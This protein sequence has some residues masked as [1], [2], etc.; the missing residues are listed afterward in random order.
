M[1]EQPAA[2][3]ASTEE[4][5]AATGKGA[6][7]N[8]R[9][10]MN[11]K[12]VKALDDVK[13]GLATELG[14]A[15]TNDKGRLKGTEKLTSLRKALFGESIEAFDEDFEE[16]YP[17]MPFDSDTKVSDK[18]RIIHLAGESTEY[19]GR[20]GTVEHIDSIGQ[21]HGTWGGLA[22]IPGVDE[23]EIITESLNEEAISQEPR[24]LETIVLAKEFTLS[25]K[26]ICIKGDKAG[27]K[28][29]VTVYIK[30]FT[31]SGD[32]GNNINKVFVGHLNGKTDYTC[33]FNDES[34]AMHFLEQCLAI[35]PEDITNLHMARADKNT[36]GY[37]IVKT[38]FGDAGIIIQKE[39]PTPIDTVI[40]HYKKEESLKEDIEAEANT[41]RPCWSIE[42][43]GAEDGKFFNSE[44]EARAAFK[45]LRIPEDIPE[46]TGDIIL[47]YLNPDKNNY[48]A[49]V[50][51][52]YVRNPLGKSKEELV[53]LGILES[54]NEGIITEKPE[55]DKIESYNNGLKLAK[56]YGK[57][58]IYGYTNK[59]LGGKYFALGDPIVCDDV[60]A[61][62]NKFRAQYKGC[63]V[64][65][66]AY[67]DKA[68]IEDEEKKQEIQDLINFDKKIEN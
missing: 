57:P 4:K 39:I 56:L 3:E 40:A 2:A 25:D 18:V 35:C 54:L 1:G 10:E 23:Y 5:P 46:N 6:T 26:V 14:L 51:L 28:M 55:G 16:S 11:K 45:A 19:D 52:D 63:S 37:A 34:E 30:P 68:F 58:V 24:G 41:H 50:M 62:S 36:A 49:D 43:V 48:D 22:I 21:L 38:E 64:I 20:E 27:A 33:Y 47:W 12:I 67:P 60:N 17:D 61:D 29:P 65:Y 7:L 32:A 42:F 59:L 9:V 13:P 31:A 66:I 8:K 15:T 44:E 53:A